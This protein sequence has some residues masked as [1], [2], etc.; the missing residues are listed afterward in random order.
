MS[1]AYKPSR[2]EHPSERL[3]QE[4]L[5]QYAQ[6]LRAFCGDAY[7]A[8]ASDPELSQAINEA[9]AVRIRLVHGMPKERFSLIKIDDTVLP[10][11]TLFAPKN[12][13]V[14][15]F[16]ELRKETPDAPEIQSVLAGTT[17]QA[18]TL[19]GNLIKFMP[20]DTLRVEAYSAFDAMDDEEHPWS[21]MD[22]YETWSEPIGRLKP[23]EL[24]ALIAH[25]SGVLEQ[26]WDQSAPTPPSV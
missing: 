25:T 23:H 16:L 9:N 21:G 6:S 11:V 15:R 24:N 1:E 10:E 3:S 20:D 7:R 17:S 19:G 8:L 22:A 14:G 26:L 4:A 5:N 18:G 2:P 13:L 12:E